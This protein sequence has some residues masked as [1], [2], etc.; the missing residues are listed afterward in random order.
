MPAKANRRIAAVL[1]S[2]QDTDASLIPMLT[3]L[4]ASLERLNRYSA[5][6]LKTDIEVALTFG[7]I[8]RQSDDSAKR[9]RNRQHARRGYDTI[10]RLLGRVKLSRDEEQVL[11]EKLM[12]L[13]SELEC[14]GEVF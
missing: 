14:L 5:E 9:E 7:S 10:R 11:S 2:K 12:L 4:M 1:K 6:F 3:D 8:A 13:K